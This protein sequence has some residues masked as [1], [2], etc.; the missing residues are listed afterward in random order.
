MGTEFFWFYDIIFAAI[1]IGI[2]LLGYK[3]GFVKMLLSL[4]ATVTAFVIALVISGG[5]ANW[6]YETFVYEPL[7][8]G[9][10]SAIDD[11]LGES[12]VAELS[13]IDLE[14]VKV[15]GKKLDN[16]NL[17][18][19]DAGK[20]TINLN[21][22]DLSKTGI[23]KIDLSGF[24]IDLNK[25]D[26]SSINLGT[27]QILESDL[28][29]HDIEQIVVSKVL[30]DNITDSDISNE[31]KKIADKINEALPDLGISSDL[32][33]N[34]DTG[35]LNDVI[36]SVLESGGNPGKAIL[37]NVIKPIVIIPIQTLIFILLFVIILVV[38]SIIIAATAVVNKI[39]L[40]GGL[41]KFLG[42]V[43]GI[44]HGL[45][46][47]FIVVILLHLAVTLTGNSLIFL[48]EMTIEKSY[49]FSYVYNFSFLDFMK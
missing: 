49:L 32:L 33:A 5:V 13:K 37:D 21:N 20:I 36:L 15:D 47:V 30:T 27:V 31:V 6:V 45:I 16:I 34:I 38:L 8:Q 19:D 24:G 42:G 25:M 7:E 11:V 9:I 2:V 39:P 23:D 43:L 40:I 4:V 44:I 22:I 17:K 1:I 14:K 46:V 12:A 3:R 18:P 26:L 48:N 29:K 10:T 41:N 28:Q 35:F